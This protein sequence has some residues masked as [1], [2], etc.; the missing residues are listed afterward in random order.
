MA[1]GP[2]GVTKQGFAFAFTFQWPPAPIPKLVGSTNQL[3]MVL[4][5]LKLYILIV[6]TIHA[7]FGDSMLSSHSHVAFC[8]GLWAVAFL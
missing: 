3:L 6:D 1:Q 8:L 5:H 4:V 7:S 2:G